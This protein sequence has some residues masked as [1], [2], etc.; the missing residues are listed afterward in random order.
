MLGKMFF[1]AEPYNPRPNFDGSII[2]LSGGENT[3]I[4][5]FGH[6]VDIE[7]LFNQEALIQSHLLVLLRFKI[8]LYLVLL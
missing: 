7:Y 3:T 8:L 1:N 5:L 4:I 6:L 2:N